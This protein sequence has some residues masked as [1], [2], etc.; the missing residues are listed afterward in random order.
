MYNLECQ[1][2]QVYSKV[3][4]ADTRDGWV[5]GWMNR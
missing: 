2:D 4:Y 3:I 5:D 1:I